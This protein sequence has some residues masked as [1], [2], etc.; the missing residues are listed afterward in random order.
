VLVT[1]GKYARA[2]IS[3]LRALE[4]NPHSADTLSSLGLA[5]WRM[6]LAPLAREAWQRALA[7]DPRN[8]EAR[9]YLERTQK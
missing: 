8:P 2:V 6:N 5:Y 3:F 4:I 9:E 1:Q 7:E